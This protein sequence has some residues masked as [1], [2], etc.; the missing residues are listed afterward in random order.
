MSALE[1]VLTAMR[2]AEDKHGLHY[3]GNLPEDPAPSPLASKLYLLGE[4]ARA[5]LEAGSVTKFDVLLEEL[6]EWAWEYMHATGDGKEEQEL[7]QV[8]AMLLAW[9][10]VN[11]RAASRVLLAGCPACGGQ[12]DFPSL[13]PVPLPARGLQTCDHFFHRAFVKAGDGS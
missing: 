5:R 2:H 11:A 1:R 13:V 8:T 4:E 7:D 6:G 12:K 10:G 9:R 3:M